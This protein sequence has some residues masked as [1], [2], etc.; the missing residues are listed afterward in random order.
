MPATGGVSQTSTYDVT[1]TTQ[2]PAEGDRPPVAQ[3]IRYV[4]RNADAETTPQGGCHPF[5][6]D[7]V[8]VRLPGLDC[9]HLS[10]GDHG[11]TV[12]PVPAYSPQERDAREAE[13]KDPQPGPAPLFYAGAGLVEGGRAVGQTDLVHV[14]VKPGGVLTLQTSIPKLIR[15]NNRVPVWT[16][17]EMAAAMCSLADELGVLGIGSD[18]ATGILSRVDLARDVATLYPEHAYVPMLQ[19]RLRLARQRP[20]GQYPT[21]YH[22]G[23]TQRRTRFYG[24]LDEMEANGHDVTGYAPQLRAE[25]QL[26]NRDAIKGTTGME[27]LHDLLTCPASAVEGYQTQMRN[28]FKTEPTDAPAHLVEPVTEAEATPSVALTRDRLLHVFRTTAKSYP[29]GWMDKG[30]AAI[31]MAVAE[32]QGAIPT[33]YD[34]IRQVGAERSSASDPANAGR[35]AAYR[36]QRRRND[37][38]DG[39]S[40]LDLELAQMEALYLELRTALLSPV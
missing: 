14:T 26:N 18:L 8:R 3:P 37:L 5:G 19:R 9:W 17:A 28:L 34:A 15:P 20:Q 29:R 24:K 2:P 27:T 40:G 21:S 22:V 31:G 32:K 13:G 12:Y 1:K 7:T 25:H 10:T 35:Q 23:N 11:L 30:L 4:A 36:A 33:V 39:V 6:V 16:E 38:A